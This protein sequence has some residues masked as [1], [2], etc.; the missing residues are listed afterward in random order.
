MS[1]DRK[2]RNEEI[3]EA[4]KA[5]I[6]DAA[7]ELFSSHGYEYTSISQIA[8]KAGISKGLIYNYYASKEEMLEAL[9][10]N[11]NKGE[12]KFLEIFQNDDPSE[13]LENMFRLYFREIRENAEV[14]KM[15]TALS[16]QLEKFEFVHDMALEKLHRYYK[17]I[18]QQLRAIGYPDAEREAKVIA[19]VFDGMGIHH[20]IIRDDYPLDELEDYL[21]SK[22]CRYEK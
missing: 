14:W 3:R 16:L 1:P 4:S 22:Y 6:L 10:E 18:E 7:L 20:L 9:I 5:R 21:I 11:L 2:S 8:R 12:D 15:I 17:L 19:A 13:V